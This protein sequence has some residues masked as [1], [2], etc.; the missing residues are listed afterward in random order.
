MRN[1][2]ETRPYGMRFDGFLFY[3]AAG[4]EGPEVF[5]DAASFADQGFMG[6]LFKNGAVVH[7]DDAVHF[8]DRGKAVRDGDGGAFCHQFIQGVLD[9]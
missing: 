7:H 9:E 2:H 6:A 4:L 5:V 8:A 1:G 3:E